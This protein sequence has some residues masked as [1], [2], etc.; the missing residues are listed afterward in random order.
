MLKIGARKGLLAAGAVAAV[1]LP[2]VAIGAGE[3]Q[4]VDGGTRNPSNNA[5]QSYTRETEI[6]ATTDTYG[7]RQSNKSN[8]GGGA[9][10]G[11]RSGEG[12]TPQRN[13]PC[14]RGTNLVRGLAFEF[15]SR[16][17]LAG[18]ITAA[19]GDNAR[20]FTTNATGVATGLNADRVD[21]RSADD[22][23][24]AGGKAADADRLDG[25]DSTDFLGD[26]EVLFAV[27]G[28]DGTV[29]RGRG[30]TGAAVTPATNTA[31]VTFNRDIDEC[32]FTVTE[33]GAT[34]SGRSFAA[35]ATSPQVVTVDQDG[36]GEATTPAVPFNLQV[37]C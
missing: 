36:D 31:T 34:A 12:G 19:G 27:V 6:I 20:P 35:S 32:S 4:P 17:P 14:L 21:G 7:T 5:S 1:T 28:A 9:V 2:A 15:E 29:V 8:N 11:C 26:N 24:A 16:G 33:S 23:L 37:V 10:Y 18:T 22:F 30:A 25:R 3:G 13:E